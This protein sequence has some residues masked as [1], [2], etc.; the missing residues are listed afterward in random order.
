[1]LQGEKDKSFE[2]DEI[3][4]YKIRKLIKRE[5]MEGNTESGIDLTKMIVGTCILSIC[6]CT[7]NSLGMS[8]PSLFTKQ[9]RYNANFGFINPLLSGAVSG[10]I[11]YVIKKFL[12]NSNVGN[13]LF[14][15]R[16]LCNGFLA[17][18]VGV[19]VGSATMH[20]F[21]AIVSGIFAAPCYLGA[22]QIFKSFQVDDPLENC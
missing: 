2:I 16:A 3:Y 4:L 13:H 17:G 8:P 14:D 21:W 22:C 19:S 20:P 15:L 6:F 11:S 1:M 10:M 12:F 5:L 9:A 7:M 18:V